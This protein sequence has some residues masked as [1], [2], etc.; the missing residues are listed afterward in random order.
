M[1][2]ALD[3]TYRRT[4]PQLHKLFYST[5]SL[6]LSFFRGPMF[7]THYNHVNI[8]L[9]YSDNLIVSPDVAEHYKNLYNY[10]TS[11]L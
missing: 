5:R 10:D 4:E 8:W 3:I 2:T 9:F 1:Y 7:K 11:F 6:F